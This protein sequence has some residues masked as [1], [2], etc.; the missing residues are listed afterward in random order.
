VEEDLAC[1]FTLFENNF[2]RYPDW[3]LRWRRAEL[4]LKHISPGIVQSCTKG[5]S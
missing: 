2:A 5:T 4:S 3:E 1:L